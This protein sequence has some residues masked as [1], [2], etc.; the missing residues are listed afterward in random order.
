MHRTEYVHTKIILCTFVTA[1][2]FGT[3]VWYTGIGSVFSKLGIIPSEFWYIWCT[4]VYL[5]FGTPVG[6]LFL[7]VHQVAF[8]H[9][10]IIYGHF[11]G[12]VNENAGRK[13]QDWKMKD[14]KYRGVEKDGQ[15]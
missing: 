11:R 4:M 1:V 12:G 8:W 7:L 14:K 10:E 2:T 6:T 15:N 9:T 3:P 13:M 5:T